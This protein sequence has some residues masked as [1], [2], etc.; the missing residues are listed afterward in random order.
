V[1]DG[2]SERLERD[3]LLHAV[4]WF[5]SW[6]ISWSFSLRPWSSSGETMGLYDA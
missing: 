4:I 2:Q 3:K 1:V 5:H 6:L